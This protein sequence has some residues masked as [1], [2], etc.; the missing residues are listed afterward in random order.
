[1]TNERYRGG[2]SNAEVAKWDADYGDSTWDEVAP[3]TTPKPAQLIN[4]NVFN[5]MLQ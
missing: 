1:M 4:D 5:R 3:E 2:T